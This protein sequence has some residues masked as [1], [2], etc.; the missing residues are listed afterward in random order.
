VTQAAVAAQV[1]QTLDRNADLT[2][3][4]AFDHELRDLATQ[5]L[6]FRFRQ[7]ADLGRQ[8]D[9]GRFTDLLRTGT[10]NAVDALQPDPDVLLGRQVDGIR[11]MTRFSTG[12][13]AGLTRRS[14]QEILTGS[15][16]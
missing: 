1:H 10:A 11:A 15:R 6:D 12:L 4:V 3:Q 9:A 7:V 5:A 13:A 16:A 8:G 14:E 2:T